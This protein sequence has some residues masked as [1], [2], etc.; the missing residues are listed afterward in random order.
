[1]RI[2]SIVLAAGLACT[3]GLAGCYESPQATIHKPHV[4]KGGKDPLLA[5]QRDPKQQ[6][7]LR[8]RFDLVQRDR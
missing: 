1:M 4:Y 5:K 7:A 6:A 2:T 3:A 8:E